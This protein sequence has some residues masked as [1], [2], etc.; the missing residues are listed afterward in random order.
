MTVYRKKAHPFTRGFS[1]AK[2][3]DFAPLNSPSTLSEADIRRESARA[4]VWQSSGA[5]PFR[6]ELLVGASVR[7]YFDE[8]PLHPSQTLV[9]LHSDTGDAVYAYRITHPMELLPEIK[10]WLPHVHIL[11]PQSLAKQLKHE[12]IEYLK[13]DI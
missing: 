7:H 10:S 3:R 12:L 2:I 1:F 6:V 5:E 13:S 4:S 11:S 9:E 8:V